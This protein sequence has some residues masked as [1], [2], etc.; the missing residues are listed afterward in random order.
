MSRGDQAD[1]RK[2][3][4][5]ENQT[6]F[7]NSQNSYAKA[8]KDITEY[9]D[10]LADYAATDPYQ[11]G[12]EFQ[13]AEGQVLAN[14]AD[15]VATSGQNQIQSQALRTGQNTAGAIAAGEAITDNSERQLAAQ[16]ASAEEARIG[17]E[18]KYKTDVLQGKEFPVQAE[19]NL[20]GSQG[21]QSN[22]A[23]GVQAEESNT[24]GFWDTFGDSFATSF[25]KTLG[26]G[27]VSVQKQI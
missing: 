23:L 9:S 11:A 5:A 21:S 20:S 27:N 25:G 14:T 19:T 18:A 1:T 6:E 10:Q 2:T 16:Q 3:A 22:G 8:Q 26:G 7:Q 24:P 12:G 4:K 13:T 15:S 17:S